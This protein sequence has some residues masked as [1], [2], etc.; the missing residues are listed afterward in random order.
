MFSTQSSDVCFKDEA[1]HADKKVQNAKL[2]PEENAVGAMRD[3]ACRERL[4]RVV[5]LAFCFVFFVFCFFFFN[6][7][8]YKL[9]KTNNECFSFVQ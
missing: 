3:L 4:R 6:E 2:S 1:D 8:F 7:S 5:R 9:Y